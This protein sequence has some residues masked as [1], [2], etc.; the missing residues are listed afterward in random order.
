MEKLL[1]RISA[2]ILPIIASV[3]FITACGL[4]LLMY[5][6]GQTRQKVAL[7][8]SSVK[9]IQEEQTALRDKLPGELLEDHWRVIESIKLRSELQAIE[10][11][12]ETLQSSEEGE[13]NEE[14]KE[15]YSL[16]DEYGEKLVRNE[17]LELEL[18]DSTYAVGSWGELLLAQE[19]EELK[20]SMSEKITTLDNAYDVYLAS[21]PPPPSPSSSGE[22]YS[23]TTVNT[24]KGSFGV[25]L[26][27][28]PKSQV[29][30]KTIAAIGDDCSDN[31]AT[32]SLEQYIKENGAYAGMA[33]SYACPADYDWC[34]GKTWSFDFALYDSNNK[35]W[36]NKDALSWSETG[37]VT[38]TGQSS[39]F[40]EK[41][42]DYGRGHVTAGI[43][44][45]P[46]LLNDG[47]IVVDSGD[48]DS[49]Q[50]VKGLR[51]AIGTDSANIYLAY[52]TGA[53]VI[54]AAYA[55]RALGVEDALNLDGGGTAAMYV[56][57]GYVVGPGRPLA[58]AVLI[59]R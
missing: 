50:E 33:G 26:I 18:E 28:F 13:Q 52:V 6:N 25:Y 21:L 51:G 44:N 59:I 41:T 3:S 31:C 20:N 9:E 34:A 10:D 19:F 57:G 53:S 12:L 36:L 49:Y 4:F 42:S 37:L 24:E 5:H 55:L 47:H 17:N 14:I 7:L 16:Y 43:S 15:V 58:T 54:D 1:Q 46:S 56:N 48:T 2:H 35:K 8:N 45:F 23:Y 30:V 32:K 39:N 38:F 27:K 29:T 40:Y 22:G 11:K